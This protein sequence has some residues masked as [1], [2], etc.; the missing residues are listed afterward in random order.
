MDQG[1][2]PRAMFGPGPDSIGGTA[3]DR[4]VDFGVN[5]LNPNEGFSGWENTLVRTAFALSSGAP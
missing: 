4:D 5:R 1:G 3:D 2:N